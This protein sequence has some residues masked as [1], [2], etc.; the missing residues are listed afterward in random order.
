MLLLKL[1]KAGDFLGGS[2]IKTLPSNAR[3]GSLISGQGA[4]IPQASWPEK[5]KKKKE[6]NRSKLNSFKMVHIK[7][8]FKKI[9]Q[10]CLTKMPTLSSFQLV[11]LPAKLYAKKKQHHHQPRTFLAV[12]WLRPSAG[13]TSSLSDWGKYCMPHGAAGRK[14]TKN[15]PSLLILTKKERAS[16]ILASQG[17]EA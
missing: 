16:S 14:R 3:G 9:K 15:T 5:K 12:L 2:A 17:T 13:S 6:R 8:S 10:N 4:K 11:L 7:K 1:S